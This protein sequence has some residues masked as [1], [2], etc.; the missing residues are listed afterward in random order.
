ML[1]VAKARASGTAAASGLLTSGRLTVALGRCWTASAPA[2]TSCFHR[3]ADAER[4]DRGSLARVGASERPAPARGRV[5][6]ATPRRGYHPASTV[7]PA[8]PTRGAWQPQMIPGSGYSFIAAFE[9][10]ATS[11]TA[12]LDAARYPAQRTYPTASARPGP[13]ALLSQNPSEPTTKI[14]SAQPRSCWLQ[15]I[16]SHDLPILRR[17]RDA[18]AE[19]LDELLRHPEGLKVRGQFLVA[20]W[21]LPHSVLHTHTDV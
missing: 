1:L 14:S 20:M 8:T 5:E 7:R 19:H 11:W 18:S 16:H 17:R 10:G 15:S 12:R 3:R 9:S 2:C 6:L 13:V 21:V 4:S